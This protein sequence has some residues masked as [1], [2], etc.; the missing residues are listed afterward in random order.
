MTA[1][2][3]EENIRNLNEIVGQLCLITMKQTEVHN[4]TL[5]TLDETIATLTEC[6]NRMARHW[7]L[8]SGSN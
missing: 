4:L 3:I 6:K 5:N 8:I 2:E 7:K 1:N